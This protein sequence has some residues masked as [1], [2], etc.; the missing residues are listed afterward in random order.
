MFVASA[1]SPAKCT[2]FMLNALQEMYALDHGGRLSYMLFWK[3]DELHIHSFNHSERWPFFSDR[4]CC[5]LRSF[6]S[7]GTNKTLCKCSASLA[8]INLQKFS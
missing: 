5:Q 1:S 8:T 4:R 3:D 2:T 7:R 6:E